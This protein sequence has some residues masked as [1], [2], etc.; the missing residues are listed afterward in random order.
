[1]IEQWA[2]PVPRN[3]L[4][5]WSSSRD[6]QAIKGE[7]KYMQRDHNTSGD[8]RRTVSEGCE[9]EAGLRGGWLAVW[10]IRGQH[11]RDHVLERETGQDGWGV[12]GVGWPGQWPGGWWYW[13]PDQLREG[14]VLDSMPITRRN[15]CRVLSRGL[16][17][18]DLPIKK[19]SLWLSNN[20]R[21][22]DC[23]HTGN[24]CSYLGLGWRL[25]E[26][27]AWTQTHR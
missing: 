13:I 19:K 9:K 10:R 11:C 4:W 12:C 6:C 3:G 7:S 18:S 26:R 20:W 24:G 27:R 14:D 16:T 1:M 15:Y 25:W 5:P 21:E 8:S 22:E 23:N 2:M 17:H